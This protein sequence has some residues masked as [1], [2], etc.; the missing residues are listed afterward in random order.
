LR[1]RSPPIRTKWGFWFARRRVKN[2]GFNSSVAV[3]NAVALNTTL[4]YT[5]RMQSTLRFDVLARNTSVTDLMDVPVAQLPFIFEFITESFIIT[6]AQLSGGGPHI[7]YVN[8][9]FEKQTGYQLREVIGK[10]PRFLQGSETNREMVA[11]LK[12]H[13][14]AGESTVIELLNYT[15][16]GKP[17][18]Y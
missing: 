5:Q 2:N 8:A 6:D 17:H 11:Q 4:D 13:L 3:P 12:K 1:L 7:L 10:N 16:D 18:W 9:A 14:L 15:K